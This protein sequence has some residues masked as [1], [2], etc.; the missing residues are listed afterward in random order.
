MYESPIEIITRQLQEQL[1]L[2]IMN[3][4][5]KACQEY[6]IIVNPEELKKAL[7]YDRNQYD[8]GYRDAEQRYKRQQGAW[9]TFENT[10]IVTCSLCGSP[11]A[12]PRYYCGNCGACMIAEEEEDD[13][14]WT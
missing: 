6:G 11:E 14:E 2:D 8:A 13:K 4:T 9:V 3:E 10:Q 1:D 7:A 5:I 12:N